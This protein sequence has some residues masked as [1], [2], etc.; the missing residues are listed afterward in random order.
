MNAD[1]GVIIYVA[2][3]FRMLTVLRCF[4]MCTAIIML[5]ELT[6]L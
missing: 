6:N 5:N 3:I 2:V 4:Q 1:V